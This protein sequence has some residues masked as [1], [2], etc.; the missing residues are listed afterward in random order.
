[1]SL[2]AVGGEWLPNFLT[3][4]QRKAMVAVIVTTAGA[5]GAG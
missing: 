5:R 2:M 3:F 4:G 1:M